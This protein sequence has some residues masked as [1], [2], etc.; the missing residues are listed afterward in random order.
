MTVGRQVT[1]APTEVLFPERLAVDRDSSVEGLQSGERPQDRAL[2]V[3]DDARDTDDLAAVGRERDVVEVLTGQP[4]DGQAD[5]AGNIRRQLR[6]KRAFEL[7]AH[8]Q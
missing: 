1:G 7:A 8:D 6:R 3:A 5:L 4:L 2:A